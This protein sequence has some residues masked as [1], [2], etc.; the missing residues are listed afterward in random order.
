DRWRLSLGGLTFVG[1]ALFRGWR[2][3]LL[4]RSRL[5][6]RSHHLIY[7]FEQAAN[8][9]CVRPEIM[10]A[11]AGR[12]PHVDACALAE[13]TYSD[14]DVVAK[15]HDRRASDRLDHAVTPRHCR[16]PR[17]AY[18]PFAL[19]HQRESRVIGAFG[20]HMEIKR[21][22]IGIG[23]ALERR[24]RRS[25]IVVAAAWPQAREDVEARR[26]VRIGADI[27]DSR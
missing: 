7:V 1:L 8:S 27:G 16:L 17:I 21:S 26:V 12:R 23:F 20:R 18:V 3:F 6:C 2:F 19:C 22:Y 14:H 5:R 10:V 4:L 24:C 9:R 15:S 13:R 11:E 25:G